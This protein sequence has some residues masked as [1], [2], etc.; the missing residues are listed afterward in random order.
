LLRT[1]LRE[2]RNYFAILQAIAHGNTR[3]NAIAQA[4][5]VGDA[6]TV[7]K[8]LSVLRELQLV[9][10]IVP[11]TERQPG[12]SR[13][14]VYRLADNFLQFW[15]RFVAPHRSE[16]EQ[17]QGQMLWAKGIQPRLSEYV[18]PIFEEICRQ[19]IWDMARAGSLPFTPEK[20]GAWWS[21]EAEIDV[22][23]INGAAQAALAIEC[24]WRNRPVG[25]N[26]LTDLQDR[27]SRLQRQAPF[28][29]VHYG[30]A[31]KAGFTEELLG[32]AHSPA[33]RLLLME[34]P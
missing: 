30:L 4:S 13:R 33:S 1:E 29:H 26:V 24:K 25:V 2:P 32:I 10:R 31:A 28:E 18:G 5:G 3:P 22:L 6:R 14:G 9:E 12:K 20:V 11:V 23:A 8:Y 15:F 7:S 16:L 34:F 19:R 21:H 27:V 17:G